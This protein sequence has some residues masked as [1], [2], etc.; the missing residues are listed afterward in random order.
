MLLDRA[1]ADEEPPGHLGGA[2]R[3]VVG[4]EGDVHAGNPS[5]AYAFGGLGDALVPEVEDAVE[6]E[7]RRVVALHERALRGAELQTALV[8]QR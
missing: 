4:H 7:E 5:C 3:G 1:R 8:G 6:V 2:A